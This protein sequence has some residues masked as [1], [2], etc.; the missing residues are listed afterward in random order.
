MGL[1]VAHVA[2]V[3]SI[4]RFDEGEVGNG[5]GGVLAEQECCLGAHVEITVGRE[6]AQDVSK[7]AVSRASGMQVVCRKGQALHHLAD[8]TQDDGIFTAK[9]TPHNLLDLGQDPASYEIAFDSGTAAF[10]QHVKQQGQVGKTGFRTSS[11]DG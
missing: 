10:Q 9:V 4:G 3:R 1:G 5:R 7:G 8:L 6:D 11:H 2:A